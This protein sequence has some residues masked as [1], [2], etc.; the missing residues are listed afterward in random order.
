MTEEA[1]DE[2]LRALFAANADP[3]DNEN[4][5]A[6]VMAKVRR[7]RALQRDRVQVLVTVLAGVTVALVLPEL[8]QIGEVLSLG[9]AQALPALPADPTTM[10]LLGAL[11]FSAAVYW[12]A[13]QA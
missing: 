4:F 11:I 12:A 1:D 3:G 10:G 6:G 2:R 5:V 7:E 13:E 9:L 8:D